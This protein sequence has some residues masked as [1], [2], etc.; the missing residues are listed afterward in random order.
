VSEWEEPFDSALYCVKSDGRHAFLVGT[1]RHSLVRLWD[2]RHRRPVQVCAFLSPPLSLSVSLAVCLTC[3][4]SFPSD[5][6]DVTEL[7]LWV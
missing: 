2:K 5:Q 4:V 1:S 6:S 7:P 3:R